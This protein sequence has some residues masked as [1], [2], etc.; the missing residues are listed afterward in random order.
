[1]E[2]GKDQELTPEVHQFSGHDTFIT[3]FAKKQRQNVLL[4]KIQTRNS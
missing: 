4:G 3:A 1:M 2:K